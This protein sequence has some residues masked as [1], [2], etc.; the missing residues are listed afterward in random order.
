MLD[1]LEAI[2]QR[3]EE[4]SKLLIQPDVASDMKKFKALNK[5]YKDLDKI[6]VEYKKYLNILSNIDNAKQVIATEKDEDFREMAKE[7]LDELLPQR[8]QMEDL[9]KELLIPKDPNDS[10]DIIM[11]IRAGAGGDEASIFAGDLYRMYSRFAE[12]MGW[13]VELIDATEGTSGGYKEIIVNMS[14]EDVYGKLKFESGVH[15]VQRVP[16]TETQGRIHTSVASVVV[17]PE[18]EELDVEIDMNDVRKD[19]FMSSGPGGQSVNTTYSAVRLTHIPTGIVAQCQDQKS[20]LK[21]FDK[22]LAVLRSRLY[23][24]ELAKKQ[25]AEGAQRKSMVGSGDRSDKIRTYNYPQGRVTDHRI[26]YTVYNLPNVMDGGIEDF[27]E[28]LRIAENAERL[29]EGAAAE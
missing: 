13:R 7:E 4:V 8:E 20:Q 24:I 27:V 15:R 17:L 19:L 25:E 11:E 23:E 21:N 3:F 10:K 28:Q 26:G 1:K 29:K 6:V 2:N 14:G 18:V 22:A 12:R 5:E 9:L 16:A